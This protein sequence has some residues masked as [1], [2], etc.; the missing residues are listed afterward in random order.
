MKKQKKKV[1][2]KQEIQGESMA[3]FGIIFMG[4]GAVFSG[5]VNVAL[6]AAFIALGVLFFLTGM[7]N[8]NN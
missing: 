1:K 4:V 7:K 3:Y 8:K 5:F 6:G 2:K